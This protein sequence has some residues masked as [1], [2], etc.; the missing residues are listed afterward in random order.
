MYQ[1]EVIYKKNTNLS[2]VFNYGDT[3]CACVNSTSG[4]NLLTY[5]SNKCMLYT[6][7]TRQT[8]LDIQ[9][10]LDFISYHDIYRWGRATIASDGSVSYDGNF[11]KIILTPAILF[12]YNTIIVNAGITTTS[13]SSAQWNPDWQIDGSMYKKIQTNFNDMLVLKNDRGRMYIL[14]K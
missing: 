14:K 8:P 12:K 4:P 13:L 2:K 5:P 11:Q 7:N 10:L 3:T 6:D 1:Y 9:S